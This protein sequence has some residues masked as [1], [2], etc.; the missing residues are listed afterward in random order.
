MKDR[1]SL[2]IWMFSFL[3]PH[4]TSVVVLSLL[5]IGEVI[6]GALQPW[7]LKIVIDN[8]LNHEQH[9]LPEPF[10]AWMGAFTGGDLVLM[11]VVVVTGGILLQVVGEAVSAYA[12]Q[13]QVDTG[14]RM[15]YDLRGKLFQHLQGLSL[16]HH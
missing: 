8:V 16:D 1:S 11:L 5:L 9:P 4:Q 13:I 10:A 3:R 2:L 14:Q 12:V 7:P 15:V 6:L